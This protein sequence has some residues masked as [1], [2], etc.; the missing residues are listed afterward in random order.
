[1]TRELSE[2]EKKHTPK[3][4]NV[5]ETMMEVEVDPT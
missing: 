2:L 3:L 4:G 5:P 1:V